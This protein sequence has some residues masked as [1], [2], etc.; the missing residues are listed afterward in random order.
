MLDLVRLVSQVDTIGIYVGIVRPDLGTTH[1]V[2][3][4]HFLGNSECLL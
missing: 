4:S 2:L 1:D 3:E